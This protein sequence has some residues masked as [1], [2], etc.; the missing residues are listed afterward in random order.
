MASGKSTISEKILEKFPKLNYVNADLIR[1]Y[2]RQNYPYY[3]DLDDSYPNDKCIF[4]NE[5]VNPLRLDILKILIIANE[6]ILFNMSWLSYEKRKTIL[7]IVPNEK[8]TKILIQTQI[9]ENELQDR[10]KK[11]DKTYQTSRNWLKF[12]NEYRA[13]L[14]EKVSDNESEL[15]LRYNQT[16]IEEIV[17]TIKT[18]I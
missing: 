13:W 1:D 16:N 14:Y 11:R 8:Y 17:K 10:I 2:F 6:P 9:D 7:D 12:H 18:H 15:V 5:V 3:K 4:L